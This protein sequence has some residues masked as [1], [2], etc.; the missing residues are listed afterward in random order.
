MAVIDSIAVGHYRL[1]L[2]P[3]FHASWD[4]VPR[5]EFVNSVVRVRAGSLEGVGA[6]EAMHGPAAVRQSTPR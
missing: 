4:P 6:G 3:P 2:E 5:R 1:P